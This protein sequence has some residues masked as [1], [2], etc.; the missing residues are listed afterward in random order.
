MET[1]EKINEPVEVKLLESVRVDHLVGSLKHGGL[2]S[3]LKDGL[4]ADS[5][6]VTVMLRMFNETARWDIN[7]CSMYLPKLKEFLRGHLCLRI[8]RQVLVVSAIVATGLIDSLRTALE[9][10]SVPLEWMLLP[11]RERRK[12][13]ELRDLRDRRDHYYRKLSQEEVYKLDAIMEFLKHL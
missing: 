4:F 5:S 12:L 9:G 2:S 6:A 7:I 1:S 13:R 11:K 10:R 3:M 8:V